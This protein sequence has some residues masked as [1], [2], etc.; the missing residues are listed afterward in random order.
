MAYSSGSSSLVQGIS[1]RQVHRF[2]RVALLSVLVLTA[3]A[4]AVCV[5]MDPAIETMSKLLLWVTLAWGVVATVYVTR[6]FMAARRLN[7]EKGVELE[8]LTDLLTGLP[9]RKGLIS[10][11]EG[12]DMMTTDLTH[13]VRIVDI[14]LVNLNKI[15]YEFGQ[16]VGDA[17]LKDIADLLLER[18]PQRDLVGR[19]GG[20]EFLVI[21]PDAS[22]VEAEELAK[23]LQEA[24]AGYRLDLDDR[25]E[26]HGLGA[27]VSVAAYIPEQASLHETVVT[28]KESTAHGALPEGAA[29]EPTVYHLPRITLGAFAVHRWESLEKESRDGFKVWQR[30]RNDDMTEAMARDIVRMLDEKAESNYAD[31]VT[32]VPG[33]GGRSSPTRALA[34]EVANE[35]GIPY[36]DVMRADVSGPE[37]RS[38]EPAVDAS[39]AKGDGVLLVSDV[40]SSGIL[41]RRCVRRL[42]AEGVHVT[43][44]A[45]ASY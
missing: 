14:D 30:E 27:N 36:R 12:Q 45:W 21:L 43:V 7:R 25:G 41:E 20:D 22:L 37:T 34:Y 42:S 15:N 40:V 16:M 39:L 35:L 13:R 17:V 10:A 8:G 38:V 6:A 1:V 44:V 3:L 19:L 28:A 9:N 31:F 18:V 26:V 33:S 23:A 11:L 2:S 24:I 4:L 5:L 29:G 32:A